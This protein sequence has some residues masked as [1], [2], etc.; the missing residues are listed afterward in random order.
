MKEVY[1]IVILLNIVNLRATLKLR[2]KKYG[3][4]IAMK[5]I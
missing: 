1:I 5:I 2:M 4:S 3:S